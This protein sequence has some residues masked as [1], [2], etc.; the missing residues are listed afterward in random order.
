M[1]ESVRV[2]SSNTVIEYSLNCIK[3]V[4]ILMN[5][6]LKTSLLVTA[7]GLIAGQPQ[8]LGCGTG[9]DTRGIKYIT[10]YS[11]KDY[12]NQSQNWSIIQDKREVIYVGNQG[13][14]M[15]FDGVS[16]REITVPNKTALSLAMDEKGTIYVGGINEIGYLAPDSKGKL[17]YASLIP[18]LDEKYRNFSYVWR[19]HS[20]REGIYYQ[21]SKYLFLWD[22]KQMKVW[23]TNSSFDS[24]FLCGG[25]LYVQQKNLGLLRMTRNSLQVFPGSEWFAAEKPYMMVPYDSQRF[26]IGTGRKGI[27]IY[28]GKNMIPFYTK[29]DDYLKEKKLYRGIRLSSGDF[30][31][32][33]FQGGLVIIDSRGNVKEIFN[34]SCGLLDE[35]CNYVFQDRRGN[36]WLALEEGIAKI[37]YASPISV[38]DEN[39]SG[40]P[41]KVLS[42]VRHGPFNDLYA[43]TTRGLYYLSSPFTIF[44][45]KFRIFT[46]I[47]GS[48]W[49]ILST[50]DS[51]LAAADKGVF[52]IENNET[53]NIIN[54]RSF[55]LYRSRKDKNRIWVGTKEGLVSLY[56]NNEKSRWTK[57]HEFEKPTAE[58][59]TIVEDPEGNLWLGTRTK[60]ILKVDFPTGVTID[61]SHQLPSG[62]VNVF[63]AAGHVMF[64]TG[65]G[66]FR[67]DEKNSI[68]VSDSTLGEEFAGGESG[69]GVFH[70]VEDKNKN[71]W[72]HSKTR[73]IQA[74]PQP[75]GIYV[76]IKKPFLRIPLA[77]VETIYPDPDGDVVWFAS[78]DGLIC[79]NIG[80]QRKYDLAFSTFIRKVWVN[81]KIVFGGYRSG[82]SYKTGEGS[83]NP[84]PII[85]YKDRNLR[86]EFAAPFF[87]CESKTMFQYLLEG[88]DKN[89]STWTEE[90]QKDYTFLDPGL[91]TFR[92][93][94]KNVYEN[95]S[96][97]A[98]F[99][100]KVLP[101]WYQTW[102]AYL[103]YFFLFLAG[104]Y[105]IIKWRS[106]KLVREKQKLE[107]IIKERTKE[108]NEQKLQLQEQSEKLKEMDKVKSRFFANI[109]HEFRT[110]LT[111]IMGP[112]EHKLANCRDKQQEWEL[113]MML[114]NS[115][116]L[117]SL[118]NQL[119]ELSKIESG[120]MKLRVSRQNI[121]SFLKGIQSAFEISADKNEVDLTFYTEKED[122]PLYFD[123]ERI[124]EVICNLLINA[125]KFTPPGGRIKVAVREFPSGSVEIS[126]SDTGPG[127]P[128]EQISSIFD[129]F[130]QLDGSSEQQKKG[131]GIGLALVKEFITLHHGKIHVNS[132][133][134]KG[135]EFVIC[136][137][138]GK[139]HLDSGAIVDL[140]GTTPPSGDQPAIS[141]RL[142]SMLDLEVEQLEPGPLE[143]TGEEI[144]PDDQPGKDI[145]LVVEDSI[146]MRQYVKNALE[147]QYNVEEAVNGREGI[148]KAQEIIPDLIISDIMMP[149]IDGY[150]LCQVLKSDRNTSH[151]PI[152][153]LTAK[154][155][156]ENIIQGLET[157]AD[158]YIT[159]PF[160]TRILLTRIKNL[161][162]LRRHLQQ[163]IDR[164]MT[165]Q[166]T[167]IAVSPVDKEF[168][169][170]LK[171]VI[172]T[173]ISDSDFNVEKLSSKLYMSHAT[174]YR[175][176]HALTGE[177]PRN[178][179]RSYRLK[180]GAELLK[181]NYGNVGD[182]AFEV[183]FSSTS[184][185]IKCF[186]EKFQQ[187]PSSYIA[188]D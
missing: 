128:R 168:M 151:V 8:F 162:D 89:W 14:L 170:E 3:H 92:V 109:S 26:L 96:E 153:L 64:A 71:I 104:V 187:L 182:V 72:I 88:Y 166:P 5:R 42:A 20:T 105:F 4:C 63:W 23:K 95:V 80:F 65:K 60:G 40:L 10:N 12:N 121:V 111:L 106:W 101:P 58:I 82:Y 172:E 129:R 46:G 140:T 47:P 147:P 1:S 161:I 131:F 141:R 146:D 136:L 56:R 59:R 49:S 24:S 21:T 154:S 145:V 148:Q 114:R 177:S 67:F 85:D 38:Y 138:L 15:E 103:I 180:R 18:H 75:N 68:F 108:I 186:K 81:G 36:I 120:T 167:K 25:K 126:V 57:E 181:N 32:A 39:R 135:T 94:A 51:L 53:K 16:W 173:N 99:Q 86:F 78:V 163:T 44:H 125:L 150:E 157:G 13:G 110:P 41:G 132:V 45:S 100:F 27:F 93:R 117:L 52:Q 70:I 30:A 73:N 76:L 155:A 35:N 112:L 29:A 159:K 149:E 43:G 130:Y 55:V 62:E 156:E 34:K 61:T 77:H 176:I 115:Q 137:P 54:N 179:I 9:K 119:L 127:I 7:L 84:Y 171:T 118:I 19:T 122:I 188:S 164:E 174:L 6:I 79:Y 183:G 11:R 178:F 98:V 83:E 87:E 28:D 123:P 160:N 133:K 169:E 143:D 66:I 158:D 17:R 33:T 113:K 184:Y 31:L 102:W 74:I 124:E 48:C 50:G 144:R 107:Q 90:S 152:I 134:G 37:E 22:F 69:R 116:R 91:H 2:K 165:L 139:E 97:E 142:I 175:K 185:F